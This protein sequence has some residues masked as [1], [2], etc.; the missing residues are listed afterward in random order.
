MFAL[1]TLPF[2]PLLIHLSRHS[3]RFT[4]L[5]WTDDVS[6]VKPAR[7]W[8]GWLIDHDWQVGAVLCALPVVIMIGIVII[9]MP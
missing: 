9:L 4:V 3:G 1:L 6:H 8:L 5:T 2:L 7:N